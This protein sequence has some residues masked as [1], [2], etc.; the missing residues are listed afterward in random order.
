MSSL[1]CCS[2]S[3]EP[4]G[5]GGIAVGCVVRLGPRRPVNADDVH[6]SRVEQIDSTLTLAVNEELVSNIINVRVGK[7]SATQV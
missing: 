2:Y 6:V 5:E 1:R 3:V 7:P 4:G